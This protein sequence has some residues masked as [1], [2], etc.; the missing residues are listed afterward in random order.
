MGEI[1]LDPMAGVLSARGVGAA[2]LRSDRQASLNRRLDQDSLQVLYKIRSELEQECREELVQQAIG[3]ADVHTETW[4]ELKQA[5]SDTT[6]SVLWID[7]DSLLPD[8]CTQY[9]ARFGFE[10][11][12]DNIVIASMRI[13][14]SG[15]HESLPDPEDTDTPTAQHASSTPVTS[16]DVFCQDSWE[17]VPVYARAMLTPGTTLKGPAPHH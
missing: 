9:R 12:D 3:A 8:F 1:L 5:G 11:T 10:P 14:A 15:Q 7:N 4:L 2:P 13:D 6:L 16:A 17:N